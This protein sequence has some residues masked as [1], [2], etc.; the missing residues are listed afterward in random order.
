MLEIYKII[1]NITN[2]RDRFLLLVYTVISIA[3]VS[4][5]IVLIYNLGNFVLRFE[6]GEANLLDTKLL[7]LFLVLLFASLILQLL[8]IRLL[9]HTATNLGMRWSGTILSSLYSLNYELLAKLKVSDVV[10]FCVTETSRFTDYVMLPLLQV[11]SRMFMVIIITTYLMFSYTFYTLFFLTIFGLIYSLLYFQV[12]QPLIRNSSRVSDAL[13]L[14]NSVVMSSF[15]NL[16]HTIMRED[17]TSSVLNDFDGA[18]QDIVSAQSFAYTAVQVPR[19]VIEFGFLTVV[20]ILYYFSFLDSTFIA[21]AFGGLRLLPHAQAIYGAIASIQAGRSSFSN[22]TKY[23]EENEIELFQNSKDVT[24]PDTFY[25][26]DKVD[27]FEIEDLNVTIENKKIISDFSHTFS[28]S[29]KPLMIIGPT[30]CG[31]ST[32]VDV[33]CGLYPSQYNNIKSG[34]QNIPG[35][36]HHQTLKL[37]P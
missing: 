22:V 3:T 16:K 15:L 30:G 13:E 10:N 18:G 35:E 26:I 9:A 23:F 5:E 4:L 27:V 8:N 14:R 2:K 31:K 20:A 1:L 34:S 36:A 25:E 12:R 28:L 7:L 32:L 29:E 19:Y 33:I 11:F 17:V 37:S 24:S 6:A 21:F